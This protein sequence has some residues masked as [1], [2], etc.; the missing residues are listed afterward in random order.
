V[1]KNVTSV[2]PSVLAAVGK[3]ARIPQSITG[4]RHAA[5]QHGKP[6]VLYIGAEYCPTAPRCDGRW[7]WH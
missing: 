7:P 6:E 2:P 1:A 3:G 5:H 4:H